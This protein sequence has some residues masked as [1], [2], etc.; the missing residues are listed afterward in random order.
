MMKL[1][2]WFLLIIFLSWGQTG[3]QPKLEVPGGEFD[4]GYVPH[5]STVVQ[6]FWF[7]SVGTDTVKIERIRTGCDCAT[8]TL[9]RDWLAPGDSMKV[10]FYWDSKRRVGPMN[11]KPTIY[12]NIEGTPY[13]LNFKGT[14]ATHPDKYYPVTVKPYRFEFSVLPTLAIDSIEFKLINQSDTAF[15]IK[16]VSYPIDE[17]QLAIP[18]AVGPGEE[19]R[20]F[21]KINPAYLDR[22]FKQSVTLQFST[23]EGAHHRVTIPIKRKI[24]SKE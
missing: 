5:S 8:F 3:A 17:C 14:C 7:K 4:F 13:Q 15:T 2:P 23:S 9:E 19:V 18:E 22:E 24:F 10:G 6:Q 12:S 20:G 21:A 16:A 11:R 1:T